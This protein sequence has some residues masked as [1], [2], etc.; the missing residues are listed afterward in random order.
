MG[1][2]DDK[3]DLAN[4]SM[5]GSVQVLEAPIEHDSRMPES[6]RGMSPDE[7]EATTNKLRRK[8]DLTIL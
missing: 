4:T 7:L 2:Q 3:H 5:E 8:M 6:L 1:I